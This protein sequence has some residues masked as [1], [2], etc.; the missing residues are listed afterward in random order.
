MSEKETKEVATQPEPEVA[1]VTED[2][3]RVNSKASAHPA[4]E[5][6]SDD[7]T[8]NE[9]QYYLSGRKLWLVHTGVLL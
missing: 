4:Q 3:T 5:P 6:T 7:A 2:L 8:A 1:N 9:G